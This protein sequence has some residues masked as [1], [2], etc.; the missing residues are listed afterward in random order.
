MFYTL[1]TTLLKESYNKIS[2]FYFFCYPLSRS[3]LRP[4]KKALFFDK[5]LYLKV[6]RFYSF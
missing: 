1:K 6:L 4:L 3:S 5:L 2:F